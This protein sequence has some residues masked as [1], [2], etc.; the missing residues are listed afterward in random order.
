M[1]DRLTA[2]REAYRLG[3]D[4]L[5]KAD[6][7]LAPVIAEQGVIEPVIREDYFATLVRTLIG[8]QLSVKAATTI[9]TRF[10]DMVGELRPERLL[11]FDQDQY[12]S[13]GVSKQ[14]FGYITD[15][16]RHYVAEPEFYE[17]LDAQDD[18]TV[19]EHLTAVK[20]IGKW[21]AKMF[22]ISSL[23]RVDVFSAEDVGLKN[24]MVKLLG[25][26]PAVKPRELEARAEIWAPYRSV[27]SRYLWAYL[28]NAPD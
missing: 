1:R 11:E 16:C 28:D 25:L 24:A 9:F 13:T 5:T 20:G 21:T 22:L 18:G 12:R 8:Q 19:I 23:G 2:L 27:A 15:L 4:H 10:M 14:K 3:A 26:D 17:H 7:L 6:P